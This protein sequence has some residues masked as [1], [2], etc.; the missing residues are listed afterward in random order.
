MT[1]LYRYYIT[2]LFEGCIKGTNDSEVASSYAES[3]DYFVVDTQTGEWLK[4]GAEKVKVEAIVTVA[5]LN[6]EE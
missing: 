5:D 3:E 4:S 2:N 6:Q 1:I